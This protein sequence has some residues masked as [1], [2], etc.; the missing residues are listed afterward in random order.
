MSDVAGRLLLVGE[1]DSADMLV[2]GLE[3]EGY[4]VVHAA[5]GSGAV[6]RL[7]ELADAPDVAVLD[8]VGSELDGPYLCSMLRR[9]GYDGRLLVVAP[10][11]SELGAVVTLDAGADD[12]VTKPY[13]VAEL[14]AR[15]RALTRRPR[16]EAIAPRGSWVRPTAAGDRVGLGETALSPRERRLLD[17]LTTARGELVSRAELRSRVWGAEWPGS[18]KA[19]DMTITRLRHKLRQAGS[20]DRV[21]AVRGFGFM[22]ERAS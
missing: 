8:I 12:Y 16:G 7:A 22:L 11:G 5:D 17:V 1:G 3:R 15:L 14:L 13:G 19:M 6:S 2:L 18:P 4:Q 20:E 21:R 10:G 9:S